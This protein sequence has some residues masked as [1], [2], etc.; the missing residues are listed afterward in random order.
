M[1]EFYID[2]HSSLCPC[3]KGQQTGMNSY[4]DINP[5]RFLFFLGNQFFLITYHSCLSYDQYDFKK[6]LVEQVCEK[7][8]ILERWEVN[9]GV[10]TNKV[11]KDFRIR[12]NALKKYIQQVNY[13]YYD[14]AGKEYAITTLTNYIE[15]I[16]DQDVIKDNYIKAKEILQKKKYSWLE[17]QIEE[18]MIAN[19]LFVDEIEYCKTIEHLI[20][21]I[22]QKIK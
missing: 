19:I 22:N 17:K 11:L 6:Y 20:K 5:E 10:D 1:K 9:R 18:L 3:S 4:C 13:L 21:D 7:Y 15:S 14:N 16:C 12:N 2:E 8:K